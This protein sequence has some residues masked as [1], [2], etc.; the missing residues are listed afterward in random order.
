MFRAS[1]EVSM[2]IMNNKKIELKPKSKSNENHPTDVTVPRMTFSEVASEN[3]NNA[4]RCHK[5]ENEI[6]RGLSYK[7]SNSSIGTVPNYEP[8]SNPLDGNNSSQ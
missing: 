1:N 8:V 3:T 7:R 6:N 5:E 4:G 2:E